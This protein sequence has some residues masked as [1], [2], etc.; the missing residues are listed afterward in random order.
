MRPNT[1]SMDGA[2]GGE[3]QLF[4]IANSACAHV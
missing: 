4:A 2:E 1:S 3:G